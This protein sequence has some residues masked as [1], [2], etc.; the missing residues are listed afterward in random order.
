MQRMLEQQDA[1]QTEIVIPGKWQEPCCGSHGKPI[2]ACTQH[3][4]EG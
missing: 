1:V 4:R 2:A 3:E